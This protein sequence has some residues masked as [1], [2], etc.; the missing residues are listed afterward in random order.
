MDSLLTE[1]TESK[2]NAEQ[3]EG[4]KMT[5]IPH[6]MQQA[7]MSLGPS[8]HSAHKENFY[9]QPHHANRTKPTTLNGPAASCRPAFGQYPADPAIKRK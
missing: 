9:P 2:R 4:G 5:G 8:R 3:H 6:D 7:L 1:A